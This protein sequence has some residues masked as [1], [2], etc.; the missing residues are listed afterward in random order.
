MET[1]KLGLRN[2]RMVVFT[3]TAIYSTAFRKGRSGLK[4]NELKNAYVRDEGVRFVLKDN[5][6]VTVDFE[7][8]SANKNIC[9]LV[10]ALLKALNEID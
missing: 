5:S 10:N 4:Y 6:N 7:N 2:N 3:E 9:I 8:E 1:D